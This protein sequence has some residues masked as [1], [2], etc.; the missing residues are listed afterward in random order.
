MRRWF[1]LLALAL[2]LAACRPAAEPN[3]NG[4]WL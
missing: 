3:R 1:P 4:I 2:A